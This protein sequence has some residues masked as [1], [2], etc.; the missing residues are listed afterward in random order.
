MILM[1][2]V[3]FIEWAPLIMNMDAGSFVRSAALG[4]SDTIPI[5]KVSSR[6][7]QSP[8]R[9]PDHRWR[10]D[11]VQVADT[12]PFYLAVYS[13]PITGLCKFKIQVQIIRRESPKF[14]VMGSRWVSLPEAGLTAPCSPGREGNASGIRSM[15]A[16]RQGFS[17]LWSLRNQ[18]GWP[19]RTSRT[20]LPVVLSP[21]THS[22]SATL[23]IW[24]E[25]STEML[26]EYKGNL[27]LLPTRKP[28][29][30]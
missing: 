9:D 18:R 16:Q 3:Y 23:S 2:L 7:I 4:A 30:F 26:S 1:L 14:R 20:S 27:I 28:P 19:M 8:A 25:S 22:S 24:G 6:C 21:A 29:L 11:F 13:L 12:S 15:I 10:E 5:H 17:G